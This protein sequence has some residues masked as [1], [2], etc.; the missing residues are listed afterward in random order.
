[1]SKILMPTLAIMAI[2]LMIY[3]FCQPGA[4]KGIAYTLVPNF[5]DFSFKTVLGAL[6]QLF[7]SMSIGMCIMITYGSYMKKDVSIKSSSMQIAIFDS[8]FALIASLIILIFL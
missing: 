2:F 3:V 8:L 4:L 1:M 5:S 6:G 7:Y